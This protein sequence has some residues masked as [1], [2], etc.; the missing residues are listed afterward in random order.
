M[1]KDFRAKLFDMLERNGIEPYADIS[2]D[3]LIAIIDYRLK[4]LQSCRRLLHMMSAL[5]KGALE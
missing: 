1:K 4:R 3:D 5:I 2:D